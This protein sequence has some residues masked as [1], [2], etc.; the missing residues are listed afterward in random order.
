MNNNLQTNARIFFQLGKSCR[1]VDLIKSIVMMRTLMTLTAWTFFQTMSFYAL[2]TV[3]VLEVLF[4]L[5]YLYL[6]YYVFSNLFFFIDY[7]FR[8]DCLE[9]NLRSLKWRKEMYQHW[10]N[11]DSNTWRSNRSQAQKRRHSSRL[12]KWVWKS[13]R[14]IQVNPNCLKHEKEIFVVKRW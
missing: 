7:C 12:D 10:N 8:L 3:L 9:K 6:F 5:F 2:L 1:Q 13:E 14:V 11:I 4:F